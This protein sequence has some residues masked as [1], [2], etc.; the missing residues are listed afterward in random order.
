MHASRSA[1]WSYAAWDMPN[2]FI[3][4]FCEAATASVR[5]HAF[6]AR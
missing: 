6:L 3:K 5:E 2:F 1:V 4:T